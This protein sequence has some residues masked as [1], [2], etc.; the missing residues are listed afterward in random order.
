M[1]NFVPWSVEFE[2]ISVNSK[3]LASS[4]V[5][6]ITVLIFLSYHASSLSAATQKHATAKDLLTL[7]LT[8]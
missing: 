7:K 6:Y 1:A 5:D 8:Q 2:L 4:T 3:R